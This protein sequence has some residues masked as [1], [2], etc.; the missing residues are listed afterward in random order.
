MAD[1]DRDYSA[2]ADAARNESVD[3]AKKF[4]FGGFFALPWLW[5]V[6]IMYFWRSEDLT[7]RKYVRWSLYGFL[8]Y[9]MGF[10]IWIVVFRAA[11]QN[12]NMKDVLMQVPTNFDSFV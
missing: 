6:S 11:L 2:R 1:S 10:V 5:L 12:G 9:T 7:V 8:V 4:F 3:A